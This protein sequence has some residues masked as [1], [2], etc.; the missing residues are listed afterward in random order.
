MFEEGFA[1]GLDIEVGNYTICIK[2]AEKMYNDITTAFTDIKTGI[3]KL[4]IPLIVCSCH[5]AYVIK[6]TKGFSLLG[7]AVNIM[8]EEMVDCGAEELED[9]I[10]DIVAELKSPSGIVK[11][12]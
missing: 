6:Q 2:D 1:I 11:V 10:K 3:H 4:N 8:G 12:S 9:D 7:D 5:H